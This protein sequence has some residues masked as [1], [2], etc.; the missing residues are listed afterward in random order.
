MT[1]RLED[2]TEQKRRSSDRRSGCYSLLL[3]LTGVFFLFLGIWRRE[4]STVFIKA[5]NICMECIG[6]G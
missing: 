3:F 6:I 2:A 5:A 4:W 1:G